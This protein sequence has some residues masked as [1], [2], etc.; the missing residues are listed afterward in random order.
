[1]LRYKE[2]YCVFYDMLGFCPKDVTLFEEACRHRSAARYDKRKS[3]NERLEFLGDAVLGTIVSDLVYST[4]NA[5]KE[6]FLSKTRS[7]IVQR[8]TLNH[9]A[10]SLGINRIMEVTAPTITHNNYMYGN[11]LE[12]LIGAIYIDQGYNKCRRIVE[13]RIIRPYINIEQIARQEQNFKSKLIEWCQRQ[14]IAYEF[15][16]ENTAIDEDNNRIFHATVLLAGI[17]AGEGIG[18]SKKE[19]QQSAAQIA[20]KR[21]RKNRNFVAILKQNSASQ[22]EQA[23]NEHAGN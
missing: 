13:E 17:H 9:I 8:E 7:K 11:A 5:K 4:Y 12:A 3:D 1:M 19:A 15:P 18:Y 22:P 10:E 14:H 21:V 2:P 6:G 16:V 20:L 23:L